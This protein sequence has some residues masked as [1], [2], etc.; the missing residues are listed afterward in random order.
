L[1][2]DRGRAEALNEYFATVGTECVT[3]EVKGARQNG[4]PNEYGKR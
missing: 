1:V 2:T 4:R 3:L